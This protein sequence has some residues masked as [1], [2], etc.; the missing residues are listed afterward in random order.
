MKC[1][2]FSET[3]EISPDIPKPVLSDRLYFA[4]ATGLA[5]KNL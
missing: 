2:S 1:F 5:L 4:V 3:L